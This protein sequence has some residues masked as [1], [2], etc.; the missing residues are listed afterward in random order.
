MKKK[1]LGTVITCRPN[2][3]KIEKTDE[4][5]QK[6]TLAAARHSNIRTA[7]KRRHNC[8]VQVMRR[9]GEKKER[10]TQSKKHLI[11]PSPL[12]SK[13][14]R[15]PAFRDSISRSPATTQKLGRGSADAMDRSAS[16]VWKLDAL[17]K[18]KV[19]KQTTT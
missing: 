14:E 10:A 9:R 1:K 16:S 4:T 11:W 12:P 6:K 8:F 13:M 2:D 5:V 7:R 18:R 3:I 15:R 17:T 19:I